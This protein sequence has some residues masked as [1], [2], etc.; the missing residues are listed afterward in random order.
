[1][2][3]I[4][5]INRILLGIL[6]LFALVAISAAQWGVVERDSLLA[7]EDNPRLVVAEQTLIRGDIFDRSGVLLTTSVQNADRTV[8]RQ[9]LYPET[10]SALG[11]FSLRYGVGGAE[12]AY[13]RI[14]RGDD[15]KLDLSRYFERDV[16]HLPQKGS[17]I[18]LTIDLDVQVAVFDAMRNQIGAAVVMTVPG[19]EILA[20]VSLPAYDP[21]TLDE[22]WET[23]IDAP[24]NPFF[25][26]VLQGRYQPGGTLQTPLYAGALRAK[27]SLELVFANASAPVML[28]E[29]E[30]SCAL[31]PPTFALNLDQAYA[32]NCPA[33]FAEIADRL[34][35]E[36]VQAILEAFLLGQSPS[37][38]GFVA[39]TTDEV[40]SPPA[41]TADETLLEFAL[42]QGSLTINPLNMALMAAAIIND[43]NAPQPYALLETRAPDFDDWQPVA[44]LP[45]STPIMTVEIARQLKRLMI[46]SA[47]VYA[48]TVSGQSIIDSGG[49]LALAYSGDATQTWFVGFATSSGGQG[50]A[51][52][53]VLENGDNLGRVAEIGNV[54]LTSASEALGRN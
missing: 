13:D 6:A 52:A 17:D 33:P 16:L 35:V 53:I 34:G 31:A 37:L 48:G 23:L 44:P 2:Q 22:N 24:D 49:H 5:Q 26:R 3:F 14:L 19:G 36:S 39:E 28:A 15:L 10:S 1:M 4:P 51:T 25:N 38:P 41:L 42:G 30:L 54:A 46:E 7:R 27:Q 21:N 50:V 9:Y 40:P 12:A 43:G 20:L 11:Y 18:R 45:R 32:Y 8:S 29:L 47:K